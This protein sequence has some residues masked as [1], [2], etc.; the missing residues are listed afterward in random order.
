MAA[1]HCSILHCMCEAI[2]GIGVETHDLA[3]PLPTLR[4]DC[5]P[6]TN[7]YFKWMHCP[8]ATS[9]LGIPQFKSKLV[10]FALFFIM[11][12]R[13]VLFPW[14]CELNPDHCLGGRRPYHSI[15]SRA[16]PTDHRNLWWEGHAGTVAWRCA[17]CNIY[18]E[19]YLPVRGPAEHLL[20]SFGGRDRKHIAANSLVFGI[21]TQDRSRFEDC[22][23]W[24]LNSI[25]SVSRVSRIG[26][27]HMLFDSLTA[28]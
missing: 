18:V 19:L 15:R 4:V 12:F 3:H 6:C 1:V 27:V 25:N 7:L 8:C 28:L 20:F 5:T 16:L 17:I 22:L 26:L 2:A 24:V 9:T 11:A 13:H 23:E 10:I 21:I 14:A